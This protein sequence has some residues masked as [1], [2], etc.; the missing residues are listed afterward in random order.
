MSAF[1]LCHSYFLGEDEKEKAVMKPYPP[2]GL[3]YLS[4]YLKQADIPVEVFDTTFSDRAT[5]TERLS[6][7]SPGVIGVYS[8]LMMRATVLWITGEAKRLG[9]T[10]VVGGPEGANYPAEYLDAGAD[11]VVI[12]EGEATLAELIPAL[13]HVG[14]HR[15]QGI[16]GTVF[17]DEDGKI[18]HNIEREKIKD[19]DSLPWPDREAIDIA[20]Y[21][22]IW[23][24]HHGMGSVNLITARGCPYKCNWCSHAVF[25]YTHRRRSP[26]DCA[27]EVQFIKER[28]QPEQVWYA[29]DV[30]TIS[31]KWLFDYAAELKPRGLKL[32]F[33]TISRAD[34]MRKDEVMATLADMGCY[35]I[36]IGSESG[37]QRILD[38]M[39]RGV[40]VEEVQQA[41][42][43]AQ[44]H[45]IEVG[46]FL[47]WG[48]DG[49]TIEDIEA[50]IE[51]VKISNPDVFFTT[52]SYPIKNTGYYK[53]V[54]SRLVL[55]NSWRDSTDRDFQVAGRHS[56]QY[57][58]FADQWL[59]N[60]V[61]ASRLSAI[62]PTAADTHLVAAREARAGLLRVADEVDV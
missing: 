3:L 20:H 15:L 21:V 41:T 52:V 61:Q 62:D 8:N 50:T 39:Q 42:K 7:G 1:L 16:A 60:E 19:I 53:K 59:R 17:R 40:T 55:K 38:A 48:Y 24:T 10:V 32:P 35:R 33:E 30:F 29:D 27:A 36:W 18:V 56:R 25:G 11:V 37:S 45:G 22:D 28:Y 4:A 31:H 9:W 46:M 23:R 49:E 51:H 57:Y 26:A 47:M 44:A 5:L 13:D 43:S 6:S 54:E 34:R 12:G 14:P 58:A 2:L